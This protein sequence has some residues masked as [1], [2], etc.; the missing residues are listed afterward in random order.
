MH[1]YTHIKFLVLSLVGLLAL[2]ASCADTME[3]ESI[4]EPESIVLDGA[5]VVEGRMRVKI[6]AELEAEADF[7][8]ERLALLLGADS[9]ERTFPHGG[10]FEKRMRKAGLHLWYEVYSDPNKMSSKSAATD[11]S[12]IQLVEPTYVI[13][14]ADEPLIVEASSV[15]S[16]TTKSSAP[17]DDPLLI[18][19]WHYQ[20]DGSL[21]N[22]F[23]AGADINL[24]PAWELETGKPEVIVAV[25]DGGIEYTH[26]DLAA[27]MWIN[28]A[29]AQGAEGVDNDDNGYVGDIHGW[30]FKD[31]SKE[32]IFAN[33][34]THVA[35]T[36]AAVNNNGIGVSGVAGGDGTP[37]SGVRLMTCQISVD[38]IYGSD[39]VIKRAYVYAANNGA[40][41]AQ[42]SWGYNYNMPALPQSDRDA[43]NYFIDHAG[44]DENGEVTG[45]MKG[46]LAIFASG[47][48]GV[49]NPV[50]PA[51]MERTVAVASMRQDFKIPTTSNYGTYIDVVAPGGDQYD[52]GTPWIWSTG[53]GGKYVS[54]IGTSM[55]CPHVSG[56]AA[57]IVSK[58]GV[59]HPGAL[60]P[61]IV[62][63]ILK[64][65]AHDEIYTYNP[66]F[67]FLGEKRLGAGYID[68]YAALT[69]LADPIAPSE[70]TAKWGTTSA[71]L[72][73]T[74]PENEYNQTPL[75][76]IVVYSD[77]PLDGIDVANIPESIH[78]V[79]V[80][81]AGQSM[82][83]ELSVEIEELMQST[84]YY[85]GVIAEYT[86][87]KRSAVVSASG[88]TSGAGIRCYPNPVRDVLNV[89]SSRDLP[90]IELAIYNSA[91]AKVH[92]ETIKNLSIYDPAKINVSKLVGGTYQV[93]LKYSG[94][95][96][97][98]NI[99]KL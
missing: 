33:H 94:I 55:A 82:G 96:V 53:M 38:G 97:T 5:T 31:D 1:K 40:V 69:Y 85:A 68:A 16:F 64:G 18:T 81:G 12:G 78:Q 57:L 23:I 4:G 21:G 50:Y 11:L 65:S 89:K 27:N 49:K 17:F 2:L 3:V 80:D 45:P 54:M 37:N 84:T 30:N 51:A 87:G 43:I 15:K 75:R 61:A 56:V 36:V 91:G 10:K 24:F 28:T 47:N 73:W 72:L 26:P 25:F 29:E 62:T 79:Y 70:L 59:G 77:S 63:D 99:I 67:N 95:E 32:I 86:G 60:T 34:A 90:L 35:G 13:T 46:G 22:E 93:V 66:A 92:T 76:Y 42:C 83:S 88:K 7:S 58:Y 98:H 20:N 41:I 52:S 71:Q 19:Q 14:R 9:V 6:T 44:T 74:V 8:A 39:E 48:N